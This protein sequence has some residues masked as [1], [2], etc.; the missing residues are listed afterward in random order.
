[1]RRP[2]PQYYEE[3]ESAL[4]ESDEIGYFEDYEDEIDQ[5]ES[6]DSEEIMDQF[7]LAMEMLRHHSHGYRNNNSLDLSSVQNDKDNAFK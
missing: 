3:T 7:D 2:R 5:D 6:F 4:D 1:M